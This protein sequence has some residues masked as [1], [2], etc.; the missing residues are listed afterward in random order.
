MKGWQEKKAI[1][2]S[3]FIKYKGYGIQ[4]DFQF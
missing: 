2:I 1:K 4:M 3:A